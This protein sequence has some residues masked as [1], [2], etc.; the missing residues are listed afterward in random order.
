[1]KRFLK[2]LF[3]LLITVVYLGFGFILTLT[4]FEFK[5]AET[6]DLIIENNLSNSNNNYVELETN[7]KFLTFNTG[8]GGLSQDQDFV[9]E[10]GENARID[11]KD[12]VLNNLTG[13]SDILTREDADIYLLQEVDTDSRRSYSVDQYQAYQNLLGTSSVLAYNYR[14]I[15]VPYPVS[16]TDMMGKVN[17]G[18]VT[19]SD[20]YVNEATR[21]QLPEG[22]SWPKSVAYLKRC[23]LVTRYPITNSDKE[24][25]VFNAHLSA[26]DDGTMRENEL[27]ALR[28]LMLEEYSKGNYVVVGGDFNQTFPQA[29]DITI[30]STSNNEVYDYYYELK[31]E[32]NWQAPPMKEDL[33]VSNGFSFICDISYPTSRMLDKPHLSFDLENNQ[34]YLI[35]GFIVSANI[36]VN[37]VKTLEENFVYSDHNP[38]ILEISLNG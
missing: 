5:P 12:S 27:E 35:D 2:I 22:V 26:Y 1:M 7:I 24:L 33:F 30:D 10:G 6:T 38:V 23:L 4:L 15:F 3:V 19:F 11:S 8:Y 28:I 13:I 9:M 32:N 34:Y 17:S 31:D 16:L 37:N 21:V 20:F 29:V 14:S 25:V 18:V 36:T